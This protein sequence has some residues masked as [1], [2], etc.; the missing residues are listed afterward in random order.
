M[1]S[2]LRYDVLVPAGV[3]LIVV[4]VALRNAA[5]STK[6]RLASERQDQQLSG[7]RTA[8]PRALTHW[9]R[10]AGAYARLAI[11]LGVAVALMGFFIR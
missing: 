4:G 1:R 6:R 3:C 11:A 9:E 7:G 10:H 2:L 8:A 5:A